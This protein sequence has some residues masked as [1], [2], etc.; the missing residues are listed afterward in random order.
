MLRNIQIDPEVHKTIKL[1]CAMN[2]LSIKE[3][4]EVSSMKYIKEQN[5]K[6]NEKQDSI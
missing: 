6:R 5:E 3:L 4:V 1:Y 2:D